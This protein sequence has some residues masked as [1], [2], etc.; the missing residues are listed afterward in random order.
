MRPRTSRTPGGE[1]PDCSQRHKPFEDALARARPRTL[2]W[3][4]YRAGLFVL[5]LVDRAWSK[6]RAIPVGEGRRLVVRDAIRAVRPR[7]MRMALDGIVDMMA[8]GGPPAREVLGALDRF[9]D[10]LA[11]EGDFSLA[12]HVYRQII[13]VANDENLVELLPDAHQHFATSLREQGQV[14]DALRNYAVGLGW[15]TRLDQQPVAIRIEI[16]LANLHRVLKRFPEARDILQPVLRRAKQLAVPELVGRAAHELG[17]VTRALGHPVDALAY[18]ADAFHAFTKPRHLYHLL[19]DIAFALA[20]LGHVKDAHDAWLVVYRA[21]EAGAYPRWAAGINLMKLAHE[22]GDA[23]L[24]DEYADILKHAKMPARLLISYLLEYAEGCARFDR[25]DESRAAYERAARLAEKHGF[26]AELQMALNAL[27]GCP[28]QETRPSAP[29]DLPQNVTELVT[30]IRQRLSSASLLDA[31]QGQQLRT[32][33]RR[34]RPP[35]S[36]RR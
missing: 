10:R 31:R 36:D 25:P 24:F 17:L 14:D 2:Q 12:T 28:T 22:N 21:L 29:A 33:L 8:A 4:R 32:V 26:V 11:F 27:R 23:R 34:G 35:K 6:R 3:F 20:G 18:Y 1:D 13:D 15:A 19:N 16:D 30:A 5:E 9:A 7:A